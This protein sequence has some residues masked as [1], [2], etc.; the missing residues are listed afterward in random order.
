MM[1]VTVC[2]AEPQIQHSL[3]KPDRSSRSACTLT[4]VSARDLRIARASVPAGCGGIIACTACA[5]PSLLPE[6]CS[7]I[8]QVQALRIRKVRVRDRIALSLK[9]GS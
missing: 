4:V 9:S 7:R 8:L 3:A 5:R 2:T 1:F 6:D